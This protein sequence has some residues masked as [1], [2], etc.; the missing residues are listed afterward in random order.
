[1]INEKD[2]RLEIQEET[3][4]EKILLPRLDVEIDG[5]RYVTVPN[6][7]YICSS[8][9]KLYSYSKYSSLVPFRLREIYINQY[10]SN[11]YG[12]LQAGYKDID[13]NIIQTSKHRVIAYAFG[14]LDDIHSPLD[15]D[16]INKITNDNRVEN[17]RVVPHIDNLNTRQL[18]K[19]IVAKQPHSKN[20]IR[21]NSTI[22]AARYLIKNKIAKSTNENAIAVNLCNTLKA[23]NGNNKKKKKNIAYGLE[24]SYGN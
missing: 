9:G 2:E 8:D 3:E 13:G 16:H 4:R 21:F 17:L 5:I 1:M 18:G 23:P 19:R 14:I 20:K 22:E 10:N 15:V 6:A 24:W 7:N 11:G 12:Y